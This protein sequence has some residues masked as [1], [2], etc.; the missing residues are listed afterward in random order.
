MYMQYILHVYTL[1]IHVVYVD[2]IHTQCNCTPSSNGPYLAN[3][4]LESAA[5]DWG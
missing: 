1:Y 4:M 5:V 2:T 3:T